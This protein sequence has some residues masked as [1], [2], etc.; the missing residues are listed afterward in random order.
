MFDGVDGRSPSGRRFRDLCRAYERECGGNLSVIG[1]TLIRQAASLTMQCEEMQAAQ[2][3]GK[4]VS[5]DDTVRM[6]SEIRRILAAVAGKPGRN[7]AAAP[8]L[9]DY[10]AQK[11]AAEPEQ[12]DRVFTDGEAA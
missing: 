5:I 6:T 3:N 7:Q 1:K 2:L 12:P 9:D 10:A 11:F 4:T 8:T